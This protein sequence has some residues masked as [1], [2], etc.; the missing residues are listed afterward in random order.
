MS[1]GGFPAIPGSVESSWSLDSDS[2]ISSLFLLREVL[3]WVNVSTAEV[4]VD[5]I[6][7]IADKDWRWRCFSSFGPFKTS[8]D[9]PLAVEL[10]V[11]F[12]VVLA[13]VSLDF[14]RE[15]DFPLSIVCM[16]SR[17]ELCEPT[18]EESPVEIS[19]S[20]W[21]TTFVPPLAPS[22]SG[23]TFSGKGYS[24]SVRVKIYPHLKD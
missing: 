15:T 3:T 21:S 16:M 20:N 8:A 5:I 13:V 12:V 14:F 4:I 9:W 2:L 19:M 23:N 18:T 10:A 17:A 1:P 24:Q 11:R 7:F 22:A 6:W